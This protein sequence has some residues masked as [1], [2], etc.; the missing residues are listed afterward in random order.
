MS[1]P[2]AATSRSAPVSTRRDDP[3]QLAAVTF[4]ARYTGHTRELYATA[5]RRWFGWCETN[6]LDPLGWIQ[7]A[8][9]EL[10]IRHLHE[11]EPPPRHPGISRTCSSTRER[12]DGLSRPYRGAP[13]FSC[14]WWLR[15]GAGTGSDAMKTRSGGN[16]ERPGSVP[17]YPR[18]RWSTKRGCRPGP[19]SG[20]AWP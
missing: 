8:H 7:R 1:T 13:N 11:W 18:G 9:V 5:L 17:L 14:R 16:G 3:A 12:C 15:T 10:H 2:A 20:L 6:H 19:R 4:L